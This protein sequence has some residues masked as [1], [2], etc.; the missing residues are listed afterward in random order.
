M[1]KQQK[2]H[3]IIK[4]RKDD[5]IRQIIITV[6]RDT[7]WYGLTYKY[8]DHFDKPITIKKQLL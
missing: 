3:T 4:R 2:T 8:D 7:R 6:S 5:S 1:Y